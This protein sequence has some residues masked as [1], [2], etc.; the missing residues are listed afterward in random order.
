MFFM[1][2]YIYIG[3]HNILKLYIVVYKDI[4]SYIFV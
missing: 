4:W 2:L 1:F 3:M